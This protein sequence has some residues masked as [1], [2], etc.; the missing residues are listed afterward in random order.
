MTAGT[1]FI[2]TTR[3]S[4]R[5]LLRISEVK[6]VEPKDYIGGAFVFLFMGASFKLASIGLVFAAIFV[7]EVFIADFCCHR[8]RKPPINLEGACVIEK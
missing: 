8:K 6:P 4:P 2:F 5:A 1:L 7:P 3:N